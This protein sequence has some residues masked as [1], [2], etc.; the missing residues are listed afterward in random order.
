MGTEKEM[1]RHIC[2]M[3]ESCHLDML[4]FMTEALPDS[5]ARHHTTN[6]VTLLNKSLT[7]QSAMS[8]HVGF[9]M[10]QKKSTAAVSI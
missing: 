5:H 2:F 3:E 7:F 6:S 10:A 1:C 4:V 8:S 9:Q